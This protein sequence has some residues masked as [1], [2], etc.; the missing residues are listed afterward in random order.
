MTQPAAGVAEPPPSV[1]SA[2]GVTK[3][4]GTNVVFSDLTADV[5]RGVTGL[6][7]SNGSGKTTL[8]G[9][10]LG[11][12]EPNSGALTVLGEDP[13]QAGGDLRQRI[14]YSPEHHNLP[15]DIAAHDLVR[16]VAVIHGLPKREATTRSSDALWLVGLGE[17]RA[18]PVGTMSTGQRQRVKLALAIA[19]DPALIL[20]DEPT[21]GLDPVQRDGMLELIR[22][23]GTEFGIDILLSS[24]L[25]EEVERIADNVVIL[26]DGR[27]TASG[28]ID[29]LRTGQGG[30][31]A[32]IDNGVEG[33]IASMERRG[34]VIRAERDRLRIGGDLPPDKLAD[35]VRDSIAENDATLRRLMPVQ[36]TL[37]DLFLDEVY[38]E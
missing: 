18:R 28:R 31:I 24:H 27:V 20:L 13:A 37:E 38:G 1:I 26:N 21:D 12:H 11:L 8:L 29:E 9:M 15:P 7:G 33:A 34:L 19:H 36:Q 10:L 32:V 16:H 17:E 5:P 14:G 6:L 22:R 30:M 23:I 3:S 35:A 2:A 4:W 25:L